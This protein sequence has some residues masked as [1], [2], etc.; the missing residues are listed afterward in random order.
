MGD[1]IRDNA[2]LIVNLGILIGATLAYAAFV[3][4]TEDLS[5]WAKGLSCLAAFGVG[6]VVVKLLAHPPE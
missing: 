6:S 3:H 1:W 4:L 2:F 5:W